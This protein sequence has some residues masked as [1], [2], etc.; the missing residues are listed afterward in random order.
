MK[1]F[2][3]RICNLEERF[4]VSK[5]D[6][7]LVI[8]SDFSKSLALDSKRCIQILDESGFLRQSGFAAVHLLDIPDGMNERETERFL[9]EEG[10]TITGFR[11]VESR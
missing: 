2:D 8:V 11:A 7:H 3:R 5:K 9:R 1:N 6:R 10:D 4:G